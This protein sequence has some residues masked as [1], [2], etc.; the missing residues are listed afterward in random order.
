M[1]EASVGTE[2][3]SSIPTSPSVNNTNN[4]RSRFQPLIKIIT[5]HTIRRIKN[6]ECRNINAT[7]SYWSKSA[8]S[9]CVHVNTRSDA[10]GWTMWHRLNEINPV[11]IWGTSNYTTSNKPRWPHILALTPHPQISR[12]AHTH[13]VD[14]CVMHISTSIY[15][16]TCPLL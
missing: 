3:I 10:E 6:N 11:F 7:N 13:S 1:N 14:T 9:A 15:K 12:S 4:L 16:H 8:K 2:M 5:Q